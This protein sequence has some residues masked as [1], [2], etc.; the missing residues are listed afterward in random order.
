MSGG[1]MGKS[2]LLFNVFTFAKKMSIFPYNGPNSTFF[3]SAAKMF[4]FYSPPKR[5]KYPSPRT[6]FF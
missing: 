2:T 6:L 5:K 3:V 4:H 1:G